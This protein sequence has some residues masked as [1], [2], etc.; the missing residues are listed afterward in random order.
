MNQKLGRACTSPCSARISDLAW[1]LAGDVGTDHLCAN[2]GQ[3]L[4]FRSNHIVLESL[5]MRWKMDTCGWREFTGPPKMIPA[6]T[7]RP[8]KADSVSDIVKEAAHSVL[9]WRLYRGYESRGLPESRG[10]TRVCRGI[11]RTGDRFTHDRTTGMSVCSRFGTESGPSGKLA[12]YPR[13]F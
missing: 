5:E 13:A 8:C 9:L 3:D 12:S 1:V 4:F 11:S 2:G 10:C 7:G 6:F